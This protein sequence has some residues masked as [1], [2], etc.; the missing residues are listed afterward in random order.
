MQALKQRMADT[1]ARKADRRDAHTRTRK[2]SIAAHRAF[3]GMLTAWG[4]ALG[5]GSVMVLPRAMIMQ[6]AMWTSLAGLGPFARY[7]L[8]ALAALLLGGIALMIATA[9][10]QRHAKTGSVDPVAAMLTDAV[11]PI[12]PISELGSE[13]LDSPIE[14]Q[15]ALEAL[16]NTDEHSS[17]TLDHP[18]EMGL[19]EFGALPGRDAVWVAEPDTSDQPEIHPALEA[20]PATPIADT[21][22]DNDAPAPGLSAIE[23]L[24]S[25]PPG[26]L[27]LVQMVERFAAALH[28]RQAAERRNPEMARSPGR[29]AALADALRAL[30][31]LSETGYGSIKGIDGKDAEHL[32]DTT[33]ELR[34]A[35]GKLQWLSGAA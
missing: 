15:P 12:D 14:D 1:R 35:L 20:E 6:A 31:V 7:G 21:E 19:E 33:R 28:E 25:V 23:K 3:V 34:E 26:D 10:R 2:P 11:R 8:A 27:S 29:D 22:Q 9:I 30:G 5:A 13:S 17:E 4:A 18:R 16:G 32:H 24:R